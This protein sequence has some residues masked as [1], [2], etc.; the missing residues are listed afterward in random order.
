MRPVVV[1]AVLGALPPLSPCQAQPS[2]ELAEVA[3][4]YAAKIAASALFVSGRSLESVLAEELAPTRPIEALVAPL[5]R[6]DVDRVGRSVTC[7]IGQAKATAIATRNLG[8][9][10]VRS[11]A[12][13]ADLRKRGA[14][15]LADLP[16]D[17]ATVDF[18]LGD[19][20]STDPPAGVDLDAL[21][22]AVDTAFVEKAA[23]P[24]IGTR[25]IVV[26]HKG[27]LVAERYAT[28]YDA[29]MPLPGWSM[30][31]TIVNALVGIRIEQGKLDLDEALRI[32]EWK[33]TDG[34]RLPLH[35]IDLLTMS[36]GLPWNEDYADAGSDSL[37]MLFRSSD[38]ASVYA[39]SPAAAARGREYQY[40]SGSTNL[41]C[42]VL[43]GTFASDLEYWTF[44]RTALFAPLGMRSALIE[45]DPSGTFVGS[46]YGF[47]TARDWARFGMLY[48]HD[49]QFDG[50][51]ILPAG[52][53]ARSARPAPASSGRFG[54]HIWLN[55]DPDGDGPRER[56]WTDLP[57]DL[58]HM[59]GHEGQYCV[60]F[61]SQDLVVVRLGCT[62]N[63]GFD[64][65]GLLRDALRA[66]SR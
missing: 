27:R 66:C 9:T 38:H 42:R 19:R 64:L 2:P 46:S 56:A 40:A 7:R 21:H 53:V 36:A 63:S 34:E 3:A 39:T 1:V 50:R 16:P 48:A 59:D 37:R 18:P 51:R 15:G 11:D 55:A 62:K 49:G 8:C 17:P 33:S 61:P 43:R 57:A 35:L 10:L 29:R 44:P 26:V 4:A 14:P 32:P 65:H 31:K 5:L 60:V 28:G 20:L 47:A 41:I 52:W 24:R 6:F 30:T 13:A 54:S 58:L 45:T 22:A 23:G 25:A 12:T